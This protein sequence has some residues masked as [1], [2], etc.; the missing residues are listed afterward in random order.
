MISIRK[1]FYDQ[2]EF[3]QQFFNLQELAFP[4]LN[5]KWAVEN[6]D[7][8]RFT[9]PYGLFDDKKVFSILNVTQAKVIS[10]AKSFELIQLGTVATY[11][12]YRNRGF[13][14]KLIEKVIEDYQNKVDGI[15]LFANNSVSDF[16]PKFGF[17][18]VN[19]VQYSLPIKD[20]K[21]NFVK[22]SVKDNESL[23][24]NLLNSR[25]TISDKF[26][27]S[28]Y[29]G[30]A[31]FHISQFLYDKVWYDPKNDIIIV[32][33][34]KGREL[35]IFDLIGEI[36]PAD[37]LQH[38]T[39]QGVTQINLLFTPDKFSGEFKSEIADTQNEELFLLGFNDRVIKAFQNAIRIPPLAHT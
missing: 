30:L 19:E 36:I 21:N 6:N 27:I 34:K 1:S 33:E 14:R 26:N 35:I 7:L 37:Y 24:K 31:Y 3:A 25:S 29:A 10:N 12:E 11:P 16:Y 39:W 8:A 13:S 23:I 28:N 18:S 32:A 2:P 20:K 5:L 17:K 15:F 22:L 4:G 38:L 9:I